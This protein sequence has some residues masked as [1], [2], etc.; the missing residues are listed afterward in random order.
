MTS[1]STPVFA[2]EKEALKT[3]I[4]TG[5]QVG[6]DHLE[7]KPMKR[8]PVEKYH[9]TR[10][11]LKQYRKVAYAI[12]I[13]ESDMNVRM[14]M[15][16][17]TRLSTLEVNAE[18]AGVDLSGSKLEG[19]ARTVIRSK[20]MLQIIKNALN[21]AGATLTW[22]DK[23]EGTIP[24]EFTAHQDGL[25]TDGYAPCEVIFFDPAA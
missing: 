13:S 12:Q 21:T 10:H 23:G 17:G 1:D 7:D 19:Y 24:V 2:L 14:E 9:N 25:E 16:H 22:T 3:E 8:K 4:E 18:L 20:N 11:L 15:E 6:V 5:L